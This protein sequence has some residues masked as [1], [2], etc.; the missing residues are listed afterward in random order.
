[1][2]IKLIPTFE[3]HAMIAKIADRA[4]TLAA[5]HGRLV[6]RLPVAMDISACHLNG[7]PL[8]LRDLL[9]A[10][11]GNF[12]HDVFQIERHIDRKTGKLDGRFVPRF[13]LPPDE[14][15]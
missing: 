11:D 8:R 9:N 1:M 3:D 2:P 4:V 7:N 6:D 15:S 10:D 13:S 5:S 14:P 12:A